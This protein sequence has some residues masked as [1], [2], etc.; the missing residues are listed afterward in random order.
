MTD[1]PMAKADPDDDRKLAD[2]GARLAGAVRLALP[3]WVEQAVERRYPGLPPET[4]QAEAAAAGRDAAADI[5]TRLDQLLA[6]DV[7]EQWTNPLT[8]IRT[9]VRYPTAILARHGVPEIA[10]DRHAVA[11]NPDDVYDLTPAAFADLGPDVHESG[12]VWGA[13][14]AHVHLRRRHG[15]HPGGSNRQVD[16]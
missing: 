14:K 9:A 4:V 6:L 5:G 12:L 7:D 16:P 13:A 8:L 3:G 10:R 15:S 2:F 11:I 1:H